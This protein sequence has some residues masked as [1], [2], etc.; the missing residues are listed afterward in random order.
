MNIIKVE[1]CTDKNGF[2]K[3]PLTFKIQKPMLP[4]N[5]FMAEKRLNS[6]KKKLCK[7]ESLFKDYTN[8]IDMILQN[9]YAEEAPLKTGGIEWYVPHH[10]VYHINKPGNVRVVFDCSAKYHNQSINDHLLQG[11][12]EFPYNS[13]MQ[14]Q[15]RSY[16][17]YW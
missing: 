12:T 3:M 17:F 4:N 6:L 15:R 14:V 16:S 9:G 13:C 7:N 5:I 2:I 10:A 11:P 1:T 8:F